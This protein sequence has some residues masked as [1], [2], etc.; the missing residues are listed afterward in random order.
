MAIAAAA[1]VVASSAHA[2]A[3]SKSAT[4]SVGASANIIQAITITSTTA[5]SFGDYVSGSSG[6]IVLAATGNAVTVDANATQTGGTVTSGAVVFNVGRNKPFSVT[7][8]ATTL[9]G[10]A[11]NTTTLA[12]NAF[13]IAPAGGTCT[14]T[15]VGAGVNC[16]AAGAATGQ[17]TSMTLGVGGTLV[18][19]GTETG[20]AYSG[21]VSVTLAYP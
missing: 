9:A 12:V 3:P 20:D 17:S 18:L 8:P 19:A 16:T 5:M 2:A 7:I 13:T 6:N 14:S 1:L 11:G 15:T 10:T 21:T 4:A